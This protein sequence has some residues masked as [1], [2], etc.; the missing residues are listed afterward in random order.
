MTDNF[1]TFNRSIAK[2]YNRRDVIIGAGFLVYGRYLLTCAHVIQQALDIKDTTTIP[3][4]TVKL[5]LPSCANL[6]AKVIDWQPCSSDLIAKAQRGQDIAA[7]EIIGNLPQKLEIVNLN[8]T[9]ANQKEEVHLFGFP[10][11]Y[12]NGIWVTSVLRDSIFNDWIQMDQIR[13]IGRAHV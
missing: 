9:S 3:Q 1:T 13:Q 4:E 2:I 12:D 7:L 11:D 6:T 10:E 8:Q 5:D